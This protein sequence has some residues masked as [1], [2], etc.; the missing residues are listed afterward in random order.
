MPLGVLVAGILWGSVTIGPLTPVCRVDTPCDGPAK[1]AKVTF[2]H[3]ARSVVARTD[4]AG[5]YRV[6][7]TTGTWTVRASIGMRI[8]PA[9]LV[10]RAGTHR[11]NFMIDTG[12]R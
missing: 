5:R 4:N 12:I 7:L 8:A 9:R 6:T 10:V 1:Q 3:G 2:S 11:V